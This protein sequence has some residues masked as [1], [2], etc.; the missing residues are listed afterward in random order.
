MFYIYNFDFLSLLYKSFLLLI[1]LAKRVEPVRYL[2]KPDNGFLSDKQSQ[3][4]TYH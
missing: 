1:L 3:T 4:I 2:L